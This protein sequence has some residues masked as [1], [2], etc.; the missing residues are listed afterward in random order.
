VNLD[1]IALAFELLAQ[2]D[3][4]LVVVALRRLRAEPLA[5]VIDQ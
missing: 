4:G 5:E 2:G 3:R 1:G